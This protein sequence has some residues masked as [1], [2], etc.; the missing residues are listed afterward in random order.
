MLYETVHIHVAEYFNSY[1]R[2]RVGLAHRVEIPVWTSRK[3]IVAKY[4]NSDIT[5]AKYLYDLLKSLGRYDKVKLH[6]GWV[7]TSRRNDR[8]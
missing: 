5:K 6:K 4:W 2:V 1:R 7:Y 8:G 3:Y